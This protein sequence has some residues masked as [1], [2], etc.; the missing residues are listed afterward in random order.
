MD[1]LK[2]F[3]RW[4]GGGE[5]ELLVIQKILKQLVLKSPLVCLLNI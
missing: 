2:A 5:A 4:G 1:D 3:W